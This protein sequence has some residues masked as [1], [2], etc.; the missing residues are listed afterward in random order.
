MSNKDI[1]ALIDKAKADRKGDAP[2]VI[3]PFP[4][5]APYKV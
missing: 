1:M 3:E 4:S 5:L 2:L